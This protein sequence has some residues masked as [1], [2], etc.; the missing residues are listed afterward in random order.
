MS[1]PA[2]SNQANNS[3]FYKRKPTHSL[4]KINRS[5]NGISVNKQIENKKLRTVSSS[6]YI[7]SSYQ[8]P[9]K[10]Y[11]NNSMMNNTMN[12]KRHRISLLDKHKNSP[13]KIKERLIQNLKNDFSQERLRR[14]KMLNVNVNVNYNE[15]Y[16]MVNNNTTQSFDSNSGLKRNYYK[17]RD[18]P[19][20][21]YTDANA[22]NNHSRF[23]NG[24]TM[25]NKSD[26]LNESSIKKLTIGNG[27]KIQNEKFI[28]LKV[29]MQKMFKENKTNSKS[30]KYNILKY[31]FEEGIKVLNGYNVLQNFLRKLLICYHEVFVSFSSENKTFKEKVEVLTN[32]NLQL[33]KNYI[34]ILNKLKDKEQEIEFLKSKVNSLI[35]NDTNTKEQAD[36]ISF[37]EMEEDSLQSTPIANKHKRFI[38]EVNQKN[39]NDLDSLYFNDRVEMEDTSRSP[40]NIPRL[41]FN[42]M[43]MESAQL[44]QNKSFIVKKKK[45]L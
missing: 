32:Q 20:K 4:E 18:Q 5:Q 1:F 31:I 24:S 26:S 16:S 25:N 28:D 30:R 10:T 37:N 15:N 12:I 23:I 41:N 35:S 17:K 8:S 39:V 34:D 6:N 13:S 36:I 19:L 40:N 2:M 42:I 44:K 14:K 3:T 43:E 11:Q 38:S 27:K 45:A 33:D 29:Q 22:L 7:N 9:T 21:L